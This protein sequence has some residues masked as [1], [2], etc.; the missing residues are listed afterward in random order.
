[1]WEVHIEGKAWRI[2][3]NLMRFNDRRPYKCL[4]F[5]GSAPMDLDIIDRIRPGAS[6]GLRSQRNLCPND[7]IVPIA[8]LTFSGRMLKHL[9]MIAIAFNPT[10]PTPY[11]PGATVD[12]AEL[13]LKAR[14]QY[15]FLYP[16]DAPKPHWWV[17]FE[18]RMR[19]HTITT[20]PV[21]ED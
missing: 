2:D 13:E 10:L 7:A 21:F 16:E 9:T 20:M 19:N 1:V 4:E 11:L 14:V 18:E 17:K 8:I 12:D 3:V 5:A 15:H 6:D